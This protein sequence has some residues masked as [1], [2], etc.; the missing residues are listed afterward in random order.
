VTEKTQSCIKQPYVF[1]PY[2]LLNLVNVPKIPCLTLTS[3]FGTHFGLQRQLG[4]SYSLLYIYIYIT[5]LF[6]LYIYILGRLRR[7]LC[8]L[9]CGRS[10]RPI[11]ASCV[12]GHAVQRVALLCGRLRRPTNA[13]TMWS[14]MPSITCSFYIYIYIYIYIFHTCAAS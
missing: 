5:M 6:S 11:C 12:V 3:D 14:V 13:Y 10:R 9:L 1:A 4:F 2:R 7:P 8:I